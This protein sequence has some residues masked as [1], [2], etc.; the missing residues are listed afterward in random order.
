MFFLD[1]FVISSKKLFKFSLKKLPSDPHASK[2]HQ[3]LKETGFD[4]YDVTELRFFC[5]SNHGPK[6]MHFKSHNA[7]LI[8]TA[9]L[10]DQSY[11]KTSSWIKDKHDLAVP[12]DNKYFNLVRDRLPETVAQVILSFFSSFLLIKF[13]KYDKIHEKS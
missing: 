7:E 1:F 10:G 6:F 3:N 2:S 8:Q 12:K 5:I 11:L 4:S 9:M 13:K